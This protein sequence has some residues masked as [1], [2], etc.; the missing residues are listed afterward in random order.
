M[1]LPM[2]NSLSFGGSGAI[3]APLRMARGTVTDV[4]IAKTYATIYKVIIM[5]I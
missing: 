2:R 4:V 1:K 5:I 3:D